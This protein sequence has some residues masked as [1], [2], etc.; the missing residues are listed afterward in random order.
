MSVIYG[1]VFQL[2]DSQRRFAFRWL[3]LPILKKEWQGLD[4]GMDCHERHLWSNYLIRSADLCATS[5]R[6]WNVTYLEHLAAAHHQLAV[7]GPFHQ[8]VV[9]RRVAFAVLLQLQ[10]HR[11]HFE[12]LAG[13]LCVIEPIESPRVSFRRIH[14]CATIPPFPLARLTFLLTVNARTAQ[15]PPA[16]PPPPSPTCSRPTAHLAGG[17][18][19]VS[20]P[21]QH[22]ASFHVHFSFF[23]PP[24]PPPPPPPVKVSKV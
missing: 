8:L 24:P 19:D 7:L 9:V 16:P 4:S 3:P 14:F 22:L 18:A 2:F 6:G 12:R 15:L 10:V 1:A 20:R 13:L 17:V 23:S 21:S 5:R 11:F